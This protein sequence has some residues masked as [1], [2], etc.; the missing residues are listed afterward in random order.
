M[1]VCAGAIV[2]DVVTAY[3]ADY[4]S[5]VAYVGGPILAIHHHPPCMHPRLAA[6]APLM[7]SD[8]PDDLSAAAEAFV[9]SC[10]RA[11]LPYATKLLWMGG[12][13]T[14]PRTA[15]RLSV[16]RAQDHTVWER[17]ARKLPVLVVQGSEDQHRDWEA[18]RALLEKL[19]ADL[20]IR[21]LDGVGHS[22]HVE[23]PAETDRAIST[24][25]AKVVGR[26]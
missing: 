18:M 13:V 24:W 23:R 6:I 5:G 11:P 4:L 15:R 2:V 25:V 10:A 16:R 17:V 7:L 9:D 12:F 19:F 26:V 21:M 20:E 8:A 22:P 1:P 3:G 14:Q